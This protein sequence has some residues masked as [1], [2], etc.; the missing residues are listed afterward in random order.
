MPKYSLSEL[1][2]N[3][4]I[5]FKLYRLLIPITEFIYRKN[6]EKSEKAS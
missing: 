2:E 1:M 3:Y 6:T 5:P 4:I